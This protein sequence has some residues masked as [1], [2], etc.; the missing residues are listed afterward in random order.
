MTKRLSSWDAGDVAA[1][2]SKPGK[3]RSK[4]S[5]EGWMAPCPAHDDRTPSLSLKNGD[6]GKLLW[7]CFGGCQSAD[8]RRAISAVIGNEEA[9]KKSEEK[10]KKKEKVEEIWEAVIPVPE[11][12]HPHIDDFQHSSYGPP[13]K[14]W[15]YK[16][17]DGKVAGWIARYNLGDGDKEIIPFTYCH[18]KN[19]GRSEVRMKSMPAP[20]PLYNLDKIISR[21]DDIIIFNEGEKAADAAEILFPDWVSTAMPGGSNAVNL[22]DLSVL[23]H[24]TV[25]ILADHDSA[26]YNFALSLLTKLPHT[27][28]VKMMIWPAKWPESLG[29]NSYVMEKGCDAADHLAAGWTRELLKEAIKET[30]TRLIH[31]IHY[32]PERPFEAIQYMDN[33]P[34]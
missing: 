14:L 2:L 26:G 15:T 8:V 24:R 33:R 10:N 31:R 3:G 13:V 29:G 18:D 6:D 7:Y 16:N 4:K 12:Y 34:S 28:N 30:S 19:R 20:R 22:A 1:R 27:T 11:T 17:E 21:R 32:L 5:G 25:V 9:P 23:A